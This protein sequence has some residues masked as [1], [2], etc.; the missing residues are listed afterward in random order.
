ATSYSSLYAMSLYRLRATASV[1][2]VDDGSTA[3][4][5]SATVATNSRNESAYRASWYATRSA[6][7]KSTVASAS[8]VAIGSKWIARA[9]AS[10]SAT[11]RRPRRGAARVGAPCTPV[12]SSACSTYPGSIGSAPACK[13]MPTTKTLAVVASPSATSVMC[14]ASAQCVPSRLVTSPST[15]ARSV[16][17]GIGVSG[18]VMSAPGGVDELD[19]TTTVR[20]G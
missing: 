13:A 10:G 20:P 8:R 4:S 19:P 14:S 2:T 5:A 18:W 15:A 3:R 9:T 6:A 12:S 17:D 11:T 1:S 7:K 16:N